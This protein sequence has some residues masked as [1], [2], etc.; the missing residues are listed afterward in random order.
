MAKQ[1]AEALEYAHERGVIHRDLKPANVK[2]TPDG[3]VKLLDFGLARALGP[4]ESGS[5]DLP[6]SHSPTLSVA[7]TR[8]GM[9]LGTAA[10][11][12]PEQANG[13][14]VDRRTDIWSFGVVLYEMLSGEPAFKGESVPD[15]LGSVLKLD[16]D[17]RALPAATP[18]AIVKLVRRCLTKDRKQ[19]LQAIGD[20]RIA[21]EE[22][23]VAPHE[24]PLAASASGSRPRPWLWVAASAALAV[25]LAVPATWLLKP[26]GEADAPL[27][28]F[29]ISPPEGITFGSEWHAI[30]PDGT[31]MALE[32]TAR[33]G[34]RML[35]LRSLDARAAAP[36]RARMAE[37]VRSGL[38]TGG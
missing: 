24:Q 15:V 14:P 1:I 32:G 2:V 11:M 18:P 27:I 37:R 23:I 26:A 30:S 38:P 4:G 35:W 13:K 28:Q 5:P 33:D 22:A 9:I 10:Y 31:R 6:V 29:E 17:W 34:T 8:A 7:A 20:A 12:S 19:R 36:S 3:A 25:A 21:I 16:P